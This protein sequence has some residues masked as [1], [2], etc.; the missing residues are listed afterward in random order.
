MKVNKNGTGSIWTPIGL[1]LIAA[2][3]LLCAYNIWDSG[4]AAAS[5]RNILA[6][7]PDAIPG[8]SAASEDMT[9][10]IRISIKWMA[11]SILVRCISLLLI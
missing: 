1:L 2:A 9:N 11:T 10:T 7:M 6:A 8:N 4:R 3:L 5:A